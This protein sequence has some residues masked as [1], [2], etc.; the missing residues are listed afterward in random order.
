MTN[1]YRGRFAPSPTGRLHFGSLVA[2]LGSWL[3]ARHAGGAWVVRIEDIDPWREVP[4]AAADI[5][6]TLA[7]FGM[8]SDEPV[9]HQRRRRDVYLQARERLER[10]GLAYRCWCSR[11]DLA[12]FDG[13]HPAACVAPPRHRP[14]AWRLRAPTSPVEFVDEVQGAFVQ[15]VA[16]DVGDF[17]IWRADDIVA[18]HLAV[19]VDDAAQGITDVVRGA[20]LLDS[21]PRQIALMRALE[22]PIPRHAHLPLALDAQGRKL[23]KHDAA[24][25]VDAIDPL[26]VLHQALRFLGQDVP[27]AGTAD[28]VLDEAARAFDAR[29]IPSVHGRFAAMQNDHP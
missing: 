13:R 14:P 9:V 29:R 22:L 26:P 23:G 10:Q 24:L 17:V 28:R 2:A 5:Q 21:T 18:Y 7:A 1:P 19:V 11:S 8:I 27:E 6:R 4:D 15:D 20:D 3:H 25:P 16:R 12:P